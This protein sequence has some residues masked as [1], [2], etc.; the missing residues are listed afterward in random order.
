MVTDLPLPPPG[1]LPPAAPADKKMRPQEPAEGGVWRAYRG[2]TRSSDNIRCAAPPAGA[3]PPG[4]HMPQA[5]ADC[6]QYPSCAFAPAGSS[7]P[8]RSPSHSGRAA[9]AA[10]AALTRSI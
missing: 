4:S 3:P 5:G 8:L 10:A 7:A 2:P 6:G 9:A 1:T